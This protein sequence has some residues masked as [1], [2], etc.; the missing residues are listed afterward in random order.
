MQGYDGR[1]NTIVN[2]CLQSRPVRFA[3]M[4]ATATALFC[5]N[6]GPASAVETFLYVDIFP[7]GLT[8]GGSALPLN[9]TMYLI[10]SSV[11]ATSNPQPLGNGLNASSVSSNETLVATMFLNYVDGTLDGEHSQ[12]FVIDSSE[13]FDYYYIR[14]FNYTGGSSVEGS[15]I[16]WGTT[17][18][19]QPDNF[20]PQ[21]E[22]LEFNGGA[23]SATNT[24]AVIPEPGTMQLFL[25]AAV[26]VVLYLVRIERRRTRQGMVTGSG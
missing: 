2:G 24:F 12:V 26:L 20:A 5:L 15:N 8:D 9:S 23:T 21:Q 11:N 22:A 4:L 13:L 7:P 25:F 18:V 6:A 16:A 10:G 3:R 17:A 14:F 1:F 19:L